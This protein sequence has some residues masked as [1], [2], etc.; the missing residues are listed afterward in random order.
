MGKNLEELAKE[1]VFGP[2]KMEH[3]TFLPQPE[4]DT[5][6]VAVHTELGKPT[7]IDESLQGLLRLNA[8]GSLLTTADDFS[9][10]MTAWLE[11]MDDPLIQQA[12]K[13]TNAEAKEFETC[14]LGWHL[15]RDKEKDALIAYQYGENTNM[16]SFVAI[17]VKEKK[18]VA[19]FTNSEHGMSIAN[20]LLAPIGNMQEIYKEKHYTQSDEP[21]WQDTIAGKIAE[22]QGNFA[23]ARR[24]FEEAARESNEES[25]QRR[26]EWFN[27]V[28]PSTPERQAFTQPL[29][30]FEGRLKNDYEEVEMYIRDGS[31]IYKQFGQP[32]VKLVRISETNFLPEKDQSFKISFNGGQM[33]YLSIDGWEKSFPQQPLPKYQLK[34]ARE[35]NQQYRSVLE[36]IKTSEEASPTAIAGDKAVEKDKTPSP[37]QI[38]PKHSGDE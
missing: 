4:D 14:G 6:I 38:T 32:E 18:G 7:S 13:P 25:K 19:F 11:N 33:R 2:L 23:E 31:L 26:L 5:N 21:G 20:Q 30:S 22:D 28:H 1:H 9:K 12:F 3:S 36:D 15:Y 37:F 10:F 16:R 27:E 17:N 29:E 35:I 24:C 34:A 8:A